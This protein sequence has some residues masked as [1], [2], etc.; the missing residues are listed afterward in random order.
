MRAA[1]ILV[2]TELI[3][4]LM[5]MPEG[6]KID[7]VYFNRD[8]HTIAFTVENPS[9]PDLDEPQA[10]NPTVMMVDGEPVWNW[11]LS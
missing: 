10:T 2:S 7:G 3:E 8:D 9:L 6:T 1:R 11:N 4:H 5:K